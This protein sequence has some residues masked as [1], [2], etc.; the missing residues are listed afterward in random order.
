MKTHSFYDLTT[1][2]FT[3][4]TF[5]CDVADPPTYARLLA[6]NLPP[7]CASI[8]GAHDRENY[9]VDLASG[10]VIDYQPPQPSADHEWDAA[11]K[12][13]QLNAIAAAAQ[14]AKEVALTRIQ[15]LEASQHRAVREAALGDAAAIIRLRTIDQQIAALRKQL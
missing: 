14:V 5:S 1:G 8:E 13:W 9:R 7:G 10:E 15:A 2:L 11:A 6:A 12:R 4:Q 3:G